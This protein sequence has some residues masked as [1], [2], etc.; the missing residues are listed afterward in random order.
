MS[1]KKSFKK[2]TQIKIAKKLVKEL[3]ELKCSEKELENAVGGICVLCHKI[4]DVPK[5]ACDVVVV[6]L[7]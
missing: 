7:L 4:K 5:I 2:S 3:D 1:K 6:N